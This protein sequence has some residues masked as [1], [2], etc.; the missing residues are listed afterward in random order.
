MQWTVFLPGLLSC[1]PSSIVHSV[2]TENRLHDLLEQRMTIWSDISFH[3][4]DSLNLSLYYGS[5]TLTFRMICFTSV[6]P[7]QFSQGRPR[8]FENLESLRPSRMTFFSYLAETGKSVERASKICFPFWGIRAIFPVFEFSRMFS[9]L[10]KNCKVSN[11]PTIGRAMFP[12]N[13]EYSAVSINPT[14]SRNLVFVQFLHQ[15]F[16]KTQFLSAE[17]FAIVVH[18]YYSA[19]TFVAWT[20]CAN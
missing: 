12:G 11:L 3:Y 16:T 6:F 20:R 19:I 15:P 2:L 9:P 5:L 10:L 14:Y 18:Y 4:F 17:R 8:H 13:W 7:V 1:Y